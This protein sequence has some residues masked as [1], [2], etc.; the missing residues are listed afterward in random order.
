MQET[1]KPAG[2]RGLWWKSFLPAWWA[3]FVLAAGARAFGVQVADELGF[4][5]LALAWV[6]VWAIWRRRVGSSEGGQGTGALR[7]LQR[8]LASFCVAVVLI[9]VVALTLDTTGGLQRSR[10]ATGPVVAGVILIG[11]VSL[12]GGRIWVPRLDPSDRASLVRSYRS[13]L[14]ARVAWAEV[15]ALAAFGGFLLLGG[16]PWVYL[17]GL[18]A[19]LAGFALAAPTRASLARDQRDLD[20]SG[21]PIDLPGTLGEASGQGGG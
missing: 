16:E 20:A 9:G 1:P 15:P 2:P 17:I 6:T 21:K 10:V 3:L 12:V 19:S 8:L 5:L 11:I 4:P 13:R 18:A 14:F 7:P